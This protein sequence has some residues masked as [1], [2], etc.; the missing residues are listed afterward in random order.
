VEHGL[1]LVQVLAPGA[2]DFVGGMSVVP[3]RIHAELCA[4]KHA[5][6]SFKDRAIGLG[7]FRTSLH[8][9]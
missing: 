9:G 8:A 4:S 6:D 7:H 3:L 1:R 2:V 5:R